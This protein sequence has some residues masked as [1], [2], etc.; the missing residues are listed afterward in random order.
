M[1][2]WD[3]YSD[4]KENYVY[5]GSFIKIREISLSYDF[6]TDVLKKIG[7]NNLSMAVYARNPFMFRPKDNVLTDPEFN[8]STGNI[9]G[10]GTDGQT[11]PTRLYGFKLTANF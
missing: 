9:I 2:F 4:V 11:P 8:Y 1:L 5:D 10:I 7:I 6:N 3:K